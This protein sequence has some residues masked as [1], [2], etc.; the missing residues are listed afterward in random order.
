MVANLHCLREHRPYRATISPTNPA[1]ISKSRARAS[2]PLPISSNQVMAPELT[3]HPE[4][5]S[6]GATYLSAPHTKPTN[7]ITPR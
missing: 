1:H 3:H 7:G 6:Y 2:A 5:H 4:R